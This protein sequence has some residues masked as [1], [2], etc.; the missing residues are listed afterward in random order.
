MVFAN[1]FGKHLRFLQLV[2]PK[3]PEIRNWHYDNLRTIWWCLSGFLNAIPL[4]KKTEAP[5]EPGKKLKTR[6]D[7]KLPWKPRTS[8][9]RG[10]ELWPI[11]WGP[12]T[13]IIPWV[14]GSKVCL[15][16]HLFID[17]HAT[18]SASKMSSPRSKNP[19]RAK[20]LVVFVHDFGRKVV[21]TPTKTQYI[22][23][24]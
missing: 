22:Q 24:E 21:G 15:V 13:L 4:G 20:I 17:K 16:L 7:L 8:I 23:A 1:S 12:K 18:K 6:I 11:F 2:P 5:L 3:R 9:F 10:Y 19:R 14:L